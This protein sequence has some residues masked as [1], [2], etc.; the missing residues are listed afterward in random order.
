M[1]KVAGGMGIPGGVCAK[2]DRSPSRGTGTGDAS[3]K[4]TVH[5]PL[6]PRDRAGHVLGCEARSD[7]PVRK[8]RCEKRF[9]ESHSQRC[10]LNRR[11]KYEILCRPG[12]RNYTTQEV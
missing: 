6:C 5:S 3:T 4:R 8:I 1:D 10:A 7:H 2:P 9:T 12:C 11:K